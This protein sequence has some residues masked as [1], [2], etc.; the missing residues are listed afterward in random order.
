M[1]NDSTKS[2]KSTAPYSLKSHWGAYWGTEKGNG[3]STDPGTVRGDRAVW[4]VRILLIFVMITLLSLLGWLAYKLLSDQEEKLGMTQFESISQRALLQAKGSLV[5]RRWA[6]VTLAQMIGEMYPNV[7]QWPYIE[8]Q[9]F[10]T[11]VNGMLKTSQGED[12]GFVPFVKPEN[13]TE[14]EAFAKAV[15]KKMRFPSNTAVKDWGFG[16]WARNKT[17]D[18][19]QLYHD[20]TGWTPYGSPYDILAPIFRTDEGFHNILLFNIHSQ[21]TTG[22]EIDRMLICSE[23]R[24]AKYEAQ[25]AAERVALNGTAYPSFPPNQCGVITDVFLNIKLGGRYTVGNFNPVYPKNDPL[26]VCHYK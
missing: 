22:Q 16:V 5:S 18:T 20:T 1:A 26:T 4:A 3:R 11:V 13:L 9:G 17:G 10:E 24:K 2:E 19:V 6:G 23:R 14:F 12:M 15:Y 8:W 7:D 25:V 21:K